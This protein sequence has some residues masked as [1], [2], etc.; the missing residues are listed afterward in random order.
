[1][2]H[3]SLHAFCK[4]HSLAKST[5]HRKAKDLG[6]DTRDGLS[7]AAQQQLLAA[8][9]LAQPAVKPLEAVAAELVIDNERPLS[10][11]PRLPHSFDLGLIR[12]DSAVA[13]GVHNPWSVA[14]EAIDTIEQ[15]ITA[16]NQ[17]TN[18]QRQQLAQTQQAAHA[19]SQKAQELKLAQTE[20]RLRAELLAYLQTQQTQQLTD[21]LSEVQM[22]GK[23]SEGGNSSPSCLP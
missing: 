9:G 21:A 22:L 2:A 10:D 11:A 18:A 12:G 19:L 4:T 15:L 7:S 6:I 3:T 5:V 17:D 8:F 14:A 20:Y 23:P 1:M 16:M 13:T